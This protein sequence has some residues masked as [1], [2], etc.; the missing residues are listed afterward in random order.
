MGWQ[1]SDPSTDF[2]C[3]IKSNILYFLEE[4]V[5]GMSMDRVLFGNMSETQNIIRPLRL[6]LPNNGR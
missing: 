1:G 5:G 2:R 6:H 3:V 4:G